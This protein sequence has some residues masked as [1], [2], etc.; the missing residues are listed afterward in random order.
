MKTLTLCLTLVMILAFDNISAQIT[1][2]W[3]AKYRGPGNSLDYVNSMVLDDSGNVYITGSSGEN[4]TGV[5]DFVTI[6]Y[7][8]KG[9]EQWVSRYNGTGNNDDQATSIAIDD[10]GNVYVTGRSIGDGSL[11]NYDYVT[12]KYNSVGIQLWVKRYNGPGDNDD[13]AE[14]MAVDNAGNIYVTGS[15]YGG[16]GGSQDYATIKYNSN[17]VQLWIVRYN[18][19]INNSDYAIAIVLDDSNNVYV[20]GVSFSTATSQGRDYATV[21]YNASGIQQWVSRYDGGDNDLPKSIAV[22]DLGNVY[23]TGN[24]FIVGTPGGT[25]IDYLTI[26]YNSIGI[27]QWTQR[28]NGTGNVDDIANSIAIDNL[29]NVYVTGKSFGIMGSYDYA[30]VKYNS[31][32]NLQWEGRYNGLNNGHDEANSVKVDN[33]GNVYMTGFS[34]GSGTSKDYST[35]KYNSVGNQ[36]WVTIYNGQSNYDD[37]AS[38]IVLDNLGNI[39]VTGSTCDFGN[40]PDIGTIKYTKFVGIT[41][42]SNII[43]EKYNLFQNFPNPFNPST[44]IRFDISKTSYAKL[45]VYNILGKLVKNLI[46]E[47][48]QPGRYELEFDGANLTSGIYFYCFETD[49]FSDTKKMIILK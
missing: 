49:N 2:E 20:T 31:V 43:P 14:S 39:Y 27:Q 3:V 17:G 45:Y 32:G 15:S 35:L 48:I 13:R 28:Y 12:I 33:S 42:I 4:S 21:K 6:K 46:D 10:S 47:Q 26:K 23:V 9:I 30:T 44:K 1:K 8:S 41:P 7:N 11:F 29:G 18:G 25:T 22:D 36:E 5:S 40:N 34:V 16:F 19:S 24:T 38:L 37:Q